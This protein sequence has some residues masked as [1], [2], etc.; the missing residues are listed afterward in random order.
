MGGSTT[1]TDDRS[2]G[3][4][5]PAFVTAALVFG[6]GSITTASSLGAEYAYDL[7]WVPV[8]ATALMLCFVDLSV[9][10]GLSTDAGP[11]ATVSAR[12]GRVVG[13][14]V[15]L[16]AFV[17][18]TSFQSGN[19]AGTGAASNVL[20]GG[21]VAVFATIFTA[22]A[23]GFLWLPNFY[24][25]LERVMISIILIMTAIFF[26]TAVVGQPDLGA[27]AVGLVP[28]FP[29]ESGALVVGLAA[30]MFSV[31]GAFYQIQLVR[32][33]GWGV[34][35]YRVARRD[36]ALG[37]LILGGLSLLI[38]IAAAAV[39]NPRGTTVE[40]PAD[41]ATTLE[42]AAGQWAASLFAVGL[43][44]AAFSSLIGNATIGGSML[45]AVFGVEKGGLRSTA[46][47]ACITIVMI[48]GGV[49]AVI[50]GGIPVQFIITAQAVTI[51][52]V[53]LIGLALVVLARSRARGTL[54]ISVAQLALAVAG[55]LFLLFL[56]ATYIRGFM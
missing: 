18:V 51:F 32:E 44:A 20:I 2:R 49:V 13:I 40:S 9:R 3:R 30:T 33:K 6:P 38:M 26:V 52:A 43:W 21:N 36:A 19:S 39:L 4:I 11:V 34:G 50:F 25:L 45:A 22:L 14:L 16:G 46:V 42:P 56:A 37:T 15:G 12:F 23:V 47:K 5:G 31:V 41:M 29:S 17:V 10:I 53:P 55:L 35:D 48:L 27:I 54:K 7:V 28:T 24:R 1:I 8:I